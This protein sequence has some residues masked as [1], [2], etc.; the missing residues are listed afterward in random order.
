MNN[1][2]HYYVEKQVFIQSCQDAFSNLRVVYEGDNF[3]RQS[4]FSFSFSEHFIFILDQ[5]ID[6]QVLNTAR[7]LMSNFPGYQVHLMSTAEF[8]QHPRHGLWQF[9][10][11]EPLLG[12]P[13]ITPE[14]LTPQ[15]IV[16][17]I[18]NSIVKISTLVRRFFLSAGNGWNEMWISRFS[19]WLV[20]LADLGIARLWH[21]S[22]TGVYPSTVAEL[23]HQTADQEI[24]PFVENLLSFQQNHISKEY[25][26]TLPHLDEFLLQLNSLT[27]H[28][29][30]LLS[31][32]YPQPE[33]LQP[34]VSPSTTLANDPTLR[35]FVDAF[36][37]IAGENLVMLLFNGSRARGEARP[38]SDYDTIAVFKKV[39]ANTL[40]GLRQLFKQYPSFSS[41]ILS[42]NEF[43][44][45]PAYRRYTYIYGSQHLIGNV[46]PNAAIIEPENLREGLRHTLSVLSCVGR[47][48]YTRGFYPR[49]IL[50]SARFQ[51]KLADLCYL[52]PLA[53]LEQKTFPDQRK[54]IN[55]YLQLDNNS[56]QILNLLDD[57]SPWRKRIEP[58]LISG[59]TAEVTEWLL[60]V[61]NFVVR[62]T[63]FLAQTT[64]K[65]EETETYAV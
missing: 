17:G 15:D 23:Y 32:A 3:T 20:A 35:Q 51:A 34:V 31:Q 57:Y 29:A 14:Q 12:S 55:D 54:A 21:Y 2:N 58:L 46:T 39:D 49:Q 63:A 26:T 47:E 64:Q 11:R 30:G 19:R 4:D 45:Y 1:G 5:V 62:Q 40:Y 24:R 16:A 25:F 27:E 36:Q 52:R 61:N 48:Y 50:A 59:D 53:L 22:V 13:M 56:R 33:A 10:L 7:A 9:A 41:Y 65:A 37:K 6:E 38:D 44:A 43:H 18:Q 28:Y 60:N 42:M 8:K